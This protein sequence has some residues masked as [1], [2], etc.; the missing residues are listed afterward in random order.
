MRRVLPPRR[1]RSV[2]EAKAETAQPTIVPKRSHNYRRRQCSVRTVLADPVIPG[3]PGHGVQI[4]PKHDNHAPL[5]DEP[6]WP[7]E[8]DELGRF[9]GKRWHGCVRFR[10]NPTGGLRSG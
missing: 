1:C 6:S 4:V 5:G 10:A 9:G 3:T 7:S 2:S 8:V